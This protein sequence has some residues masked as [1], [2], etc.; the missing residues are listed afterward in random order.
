[1]NFNDWIIMRLN[2]EIKMHY[3]ILESE[4][5]EREL[6]KELGEWNIFDEILYYLK[7][8]WNKIIN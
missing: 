6:K 1:M 2:H 7:N 3:L 8:L 4:K 5:R